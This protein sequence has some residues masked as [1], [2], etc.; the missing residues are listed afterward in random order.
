MK[1]QKTFPLVVLSLFG[2]CW[3][4]AAARQLR[5]RLRGDAHC[6]SW[7]QRDN[8]SS[9]LYFCAKKPDIWS[10]I[11]FNFANTVHSQARV[12]YRRQLLT[13]TM[14]LDWGDIVGKVRPWLLLCT[15]NH[16]AAKRGLLI[17]FLALLTCTFIFPL[18]HNIFLL[19]GV[20]SFRF[21]IEKKRPFTQKCFS[22]IWLC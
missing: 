5:L 8:G 12:W 18:T 2:W 16:L 4:D 1:W 6:W 22:R 9:G 21:W 15:F 10:E 11:N 19:S 14:N 7:A 3:R 17:M 13:T 20:K